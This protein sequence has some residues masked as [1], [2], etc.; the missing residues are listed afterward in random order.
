MSTASHITERFYMFK[1]D[2]TITKRNSFSVDIDSPEEMHKEIHGWE[3][4]GDRVKDIDK[5]TL[6]FV[7]NIH[8]E[9]I[10]FKDGHAIIK[11][12]T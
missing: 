9:R 4:L 6:E 11:Q 1:V 5:Y 10:E 8:E 2:V 3:E 12:V 7:R